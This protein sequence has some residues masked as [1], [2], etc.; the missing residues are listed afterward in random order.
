MLKDVSGSADVIADV[1]RQDIERQA[2]GMSLVGANMDRLTW[3]NNMKKTSQT[4]PLRIDTVPVGSFGGAIGMTLCPGKRITSAVSG[5]WERDLDT[6]MAAIA[7]WGADLILSLMEPHEFAQLGIPGFAESLPAGIAHSVMPI[8][9]GGVPSGNWERAWLREGPHLRERLALGGRILIHCRGGLGRTGIVAARLLVE[10]GEDPAAAIRRVRAARPGTIENRRQEE[11]VLRQPPLSAPVP[12]PTVA[13]DPARQAKFRGCLL[14][15]AAGDALGAPVEFMDIAAIR[16]RFGAGGIRDYQPYAGKAGAITDDTQMTLFTAEGLLRSANRG[17]M[18]GIRPD[19]VGVLANAY[20]RWLHTQGEGS[21]RDT[22]F[23][24]GWLIRNRDLFAR[25]APGITCLGALRAMG[26][27]GQRAGNDS[28]GCG[29]V[30]RAAPVG[31]FV[32][33]WECDAAEQARLAFDLACDFAAITHGHPA[34]QH[35]AGVLAVLVLRLVQGST[36]PDALAETRTLLATRPDH[37]ETLAAIDLAI[38]LA[39]GDGNPDA[40][41]RRLGEGWTGEEALAIALYCALRAESLE[42]GICLAVNLT[43][44]SDT[45]GAIAGNL[46]GAL[47]GVDAIPERWLAPLELRDV[48]EEVADD[49]LSW[50]HW[51]VSEYLPEEPALR[52]AAAYW[53]D[54]YPDN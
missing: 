52:T 27:D 1:W 45:T 22:A 51:P 18:R 30:M 2:H 41:L 6:D 40:H 44:D 29:G 36:L 20:R 16:A 46:L 43:G 21:R 5:E 12:R 31:L 26:A 17:K 9:D 34:G 38:T 35:P 15:G 47:H 39:A 28:K 54:R 13:V 42:E 3:E 37:G 19:F 53:L 49:L 23:L 48:I 7:Q 10:F 33:G 32:A 8:V 11:Y 14:G 24:S 50:P 25:R 4:H